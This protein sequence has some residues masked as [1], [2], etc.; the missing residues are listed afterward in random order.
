VNVITSTYL[1]WHPFVVI[2]SLWNGKN[3]EML[4]VIKL[5]DAIKIR[6]IAKS[7]PIITNVSLIKRI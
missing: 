7:Q 6:N 2:A 4:V 5:S 1:D 3:P